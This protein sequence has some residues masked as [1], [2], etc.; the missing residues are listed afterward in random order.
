MTTRMGAPWRGVP[1][2]YGHW[3]IVH[4]LFS[5]LAAGRNVEDDPDLVADPGGRPWPDHLGGV[6]A[7]DSA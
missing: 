2:R 3:R 6:G 1:A 4:G 5:G 7:R